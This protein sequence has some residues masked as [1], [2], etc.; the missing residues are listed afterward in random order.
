[1]SKFLLLTNVKDY[2]WTSPKYPQLAQL[3]AKN[4]RPY[5]R[6]IIKIVD[7]ARTRPLCGVNFCDGWESDINKM[8]A[9][10]KV[11]KLGQDSKHDK[12]YVCK[13]CYIRAKSLN[14]LQVA[15]Q[16]KAGGSSYIFPDD[17]TL[18]ELEDLVNY[19]SISEKKKQNKENGNT[20]K[21]S[22]K[23]KP[24]VL[25]STSAKLPEHYINALKIL[26]LKYNLGQSKL[27]MNIIDTYCSDLNIKDVDNANDLCEKFNV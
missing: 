27:W 21:R 16:Q 1:M 6:H 23:V 7:G 20:R 15:Y 11:I 13:T 3:D 14:I 18:D 9:H 2:L 12:D 17:I 25:K 5:A 8:S 10:T 24:V 19:T 22:K 4:I 26:R